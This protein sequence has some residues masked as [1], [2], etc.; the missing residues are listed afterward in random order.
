MI[1]RFFELITGKT[2]S[3]KTFYAEKRANDYVKKGGIVFMY[4][5]GKGL[6]DYIEIEI[7]TAP[8]CQILIEKTKGSTEARHFKINPQLNYFKIH[9]N[10]EYIK[11]I[12]S[13]KIK[14][15]EKNIFE[16]KDFYNLFIQKDMPKKF[17]VFGG[18]LDRTDEI[19]FFTTIKRYFS[20]ILLMCD[21]TKALF[22]GG[23]TQSATNLFNSINHTGTHLQ[24]PYK[25]DGCDVILIYHDFDDIK[26]DFFVGATHLTMFN[27]LN[28]PTFQNFKN[29]IGKDFAKANHKRLLTDPTFTRYTIELRPLDNTKKQIIRNIKFLPN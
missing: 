11:K 12:S 5:S 23:L 29:E 3:G 13:D 6:S 9:L 7:L 2:R 22:Q 17:K 1:Q 14:F 27:D 18:R 21:D 19:L 25:N 26:N 10:D 15:L 8:E 24:P 4:N 20:N 28:T 16:F